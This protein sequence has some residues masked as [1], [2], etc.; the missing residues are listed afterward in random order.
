MTASATTALL[1]FARCI[2]F[3]MRAPGF[4]QNSVPK[5][6]NAFALVLALALT[7]LAGKTQAHSRSRSRC[8]VRRRSGR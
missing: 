5:P 1:F 3:V 7:P 4:S 8:S 2:G 6:C